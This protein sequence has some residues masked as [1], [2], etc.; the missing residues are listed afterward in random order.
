MKALLPYASALLLATSLQINA[1]ESRAPDEAALKAMMA[2]FVP[3]D[4]RVD[5][6]KLPPNERLALAK[7]VEAAKICDALFLRQRAPLNETWLQGLVRDES[8][9]GRARLHYFR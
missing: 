6:T 9:L 1:A 4:I 7:M 5:T 3:V 8:P 2:R